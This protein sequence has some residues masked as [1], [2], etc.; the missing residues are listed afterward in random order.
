MPDPMVVLLALGTAAVVAAAVLLLCGW[1]WRGPRP[2]RLAAGW[3]V[4][5]GAAFYL[6]CRVLGLWPRWPPREDLDRFLLLVLPAAVA[7]ELLAAVPKVPRRL[8]WALRV[9]PSRPRPRFRRHSTAQV[10]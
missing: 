6:G 5:V 10:T 9:W 8:I 3:V 7:V 2:G 4:G 1:P